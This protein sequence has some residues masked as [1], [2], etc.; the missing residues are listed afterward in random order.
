MEKKDSVQVTEKEWPERQV[1]NKENVLSWKSK[2]EC[3]LS[4]VRISGSGMTTLR[5][6][7]G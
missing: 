3:S 2:E 5:F 4:K 7:S 1:E 6:F